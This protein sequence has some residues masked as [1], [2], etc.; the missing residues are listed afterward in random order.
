MAKRQF[1]IWK[2]L[3]E[4]KIEKSTGSIFNFVFLCAF[5]IVDLASGNWRDTPIFGGNIIVE[6]QIP[7][8]ATRLAFIAANKSH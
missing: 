6:L 4:R 7:V 2:R 3:S 1:L 5:A 8:T